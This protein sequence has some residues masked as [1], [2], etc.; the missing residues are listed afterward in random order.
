MAT[1][2][3]DMLRRAGRP[4]QPR[5]LAS[6]FAVRSAGSA[7]GRIERVLAVLAVAGSVH[8]TEA[9]WYAPRRMI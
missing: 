4:M 9:G 2:L 3:L 5:A 8:R 6:G 1:A 7:A